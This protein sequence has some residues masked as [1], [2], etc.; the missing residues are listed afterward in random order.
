M[1]QRDYPIKQNM[2]RN[3]PTTLF[4][5]EYNSDGFPR[6]SYESIDSKYDVNDYDSTGTKYY[7][8]EIK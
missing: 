7:E 8:Y 2:N 1:L 3:I 4:H 5:Y 6:F